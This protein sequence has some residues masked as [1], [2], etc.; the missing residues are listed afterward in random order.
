MKIISIRPETKD[1]KTTKKFFKTKSCFFKKINKIGKPLTSLIT[2]K[3]DI[4]P[5]T[6]E[7]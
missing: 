4:T 1:R 7:I 6:T 5:D 2:A 3:G